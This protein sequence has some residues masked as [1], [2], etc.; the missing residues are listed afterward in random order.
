MVILGIDPGLRRTGFGLVRAEGPG[1]PPVYLSSGIIEPPVTAS[2]PER[3]SIIARGV[4]ELV[5]TY[6]PQLAAMEQVFLNRNPRTTLL[7]GQA[8][9]AA[10]CA[11]DG[12]PQ[13]LCELSPSEVKQSVVG[14]GRAAK[15][16]VQAMVRHL[17]R[18][19]AAPS[20]DAADALACA[21]A[22]WF[23]TSSPLH[24]VISTRRGLT[25]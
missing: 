2:M 23:R 14:T 11:L 21:L 10:L 13:G 25:P 16:Q 18:L 5:A 6:S 3:L 8:R 12:I 9:G 20:P 4:A 1:Q 7:L 15:E 17:L 22:A 24:Q 19:S